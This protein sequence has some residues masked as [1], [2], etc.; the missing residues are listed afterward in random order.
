SSP[1]PSWGRGKA[2]TTATP[3]GAPVTKRDRRERRRDPLPSGLCPSAQDSHL[4]GAGLAAGRSRA[5]T[6]PPRG[7]LE[8][9]S[10]HRRSGLSPN[11]EGSDLL[12]SP[13]ENTNLD[14][15]C[16]VFQF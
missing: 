1:R 6:S 15:N 7:S 3:A 12:T 4:V 14:G 8:R 16:N 10:R 11:P 13:F 9:I 2:A 5:W